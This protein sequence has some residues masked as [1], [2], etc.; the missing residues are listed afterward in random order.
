MNDV[1]GPS[2][3]LVANTWIKPQAV[4]WKGKVGN[5]NFMKWQN[6]ERACRLLRHAIAKFVPHY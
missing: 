6:G 1:Y 2:T 4:F 5:S 3:T